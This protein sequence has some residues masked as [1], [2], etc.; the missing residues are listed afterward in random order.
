VVADPEHWVN[1]LPGG[2]FHNS[3]PHALYKITDLIPDSSFDVEGRWY[4]P[5]PASGAP[6]ELRVTLYGRSS[7]GSIVFSSAARPL[8]RK[9]VVLGTRRS[10]EVDFDA[11]TLRLCRA[12]SAPG[13]FG[14][15]EQPLRQALEALRSLGHNARA[16]SQSRLHYFAGMRA[17]M[18]AFYRSIREGAP[19]PIAPGEILRVTR[20]M[21]QI[22]AVCSVATTS[23][24]LGHS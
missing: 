16:F 5:S 7:S 17:L 21:D 24:P 14:K 6:S 23:R 12:P 19:P 4:V 20:L 3:L 10:I 2:L 18:T 11:G 8:Q 9:V 1:R 13:P 15:L 22:F